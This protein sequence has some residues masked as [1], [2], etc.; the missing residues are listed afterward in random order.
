MPGLRLAPSALALKA[1]AQEMAVPAIGK[2]RAC[3]CVRQLAGSGAAPAGAFCAFA[4]E[5]SVNGGWHL[6]GGF[7]QEM[8]HVY[9]VYRVTTVYHAFVS[10]Y[11]V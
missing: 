8:C 11:S 10:H 4:S 3:L 7:V 9:C 1:A 6:E 2:A 5:A